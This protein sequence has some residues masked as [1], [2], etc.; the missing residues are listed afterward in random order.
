MLIVITKDPVI[1]KFRQQP[2]SGAPAWGP[3]HILD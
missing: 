2:H 1:V 3:V